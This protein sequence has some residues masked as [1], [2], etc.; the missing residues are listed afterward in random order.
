MVLSIGAIAFCLGTI[1]IHGMGGLYSLVLVS[2]CMSLMFP[3]IYGI[4][5]YG[6]G[7]D[8]KPA[9]AFLVMAIV[10]GA[11][12]PIIQ[13]Y[14]L[15]IGGSGYVDVTILGVPEVNFSFILARAISSFANSVAASCAFVTAAVRVMNPSV[16]ASLM[17]CNICLCSANPASAFSCCSISILILN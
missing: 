14:I 2:F 17:S 3:T 5:L 15:D 10:G 8:A 11:F 4:A 13:G 6:L 16:S 1:F 12:M 7:D 9:S